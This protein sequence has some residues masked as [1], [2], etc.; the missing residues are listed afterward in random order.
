MEIKFSRQI[1]ELGRIVI[2]ADIRREY[3]LKVGDKVCFNACDDGII[4]CLE[5]CKDDERKKK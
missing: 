3:G 2:P 1:D 5:D 4:I